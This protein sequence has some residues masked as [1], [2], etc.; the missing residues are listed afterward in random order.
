MND[1]SF[2]EGEKKKNIKEESFPLLIRN[3]SLQDIQDDNELKNKLTS[4]GASGFAKVGPNSKPNSSLIKMF[5]HRSEARL[6]FLLMRQVN[7]QTKATRYEIKT[8]AMTKRVTQC[9]TCH[10][11]G[12]EADKCSK[13]ELVCAYCNEEHPTEDCTVKDD[14]GCYYCANCTDVHDS[15]NRAKCEKLKQAEEI[16][17]K[18]E[19]ENLRDIENKKKH[20]QFGSSSTIENTSGF[21]SRGS[22][23]SATTYDRNE[24]IEKIGNM[25]RD[26]ESKRDLKD[27]EQKSFMKEM[28]ENQT[29]ALVASTHSQIQRAKAE[30]AHEF[31]NKLNAREIK[32]KNDIINL[33]QSGPIKDLK[34]IDPVSVG[35]TQ[36]IEEYERNYLNVLRK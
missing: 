26:T 14:P 19:I 28:F 4:L 36:E 1:K 21:A 5:C 27:D 11:V 22:Y 30:M 12:H 32:I 13:E 7:C 25:L 34:Q 17:Q 33:I 16:L 23:S 15:Y 35:S 31:D 20:Q 24:D 6:N 8:M 29:K 2:F 10:E 18:L 3:V 9:D